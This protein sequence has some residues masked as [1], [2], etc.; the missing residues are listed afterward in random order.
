MQF[1]PVSF[2][3]YDWVLALEVAHKVWPTLLSPYGTHLPNLKH[4]VK[5]VSL[6]FYQ[7]ITHFPDHHQNTVGNVLKHDGKT[8]KCHV[9]VHLY[10]K[11]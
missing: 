2:Q 7:C 4:I 8:L 11:R 9:C 6:K 5:T 3:C 1:G 10:V